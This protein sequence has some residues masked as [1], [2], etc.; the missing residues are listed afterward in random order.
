MI[1]QK[2]SSE[3]LLSLTFN[4]VPDCHK[5]NSISTSEEQRV[6]IV[7]LNLSLWAPSG[8]SSLWKNCLND[9]FFKKYNLFQ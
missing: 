1:L 5:V 3:H 6:R 4:A 2:S 8:G 9:F 7:V